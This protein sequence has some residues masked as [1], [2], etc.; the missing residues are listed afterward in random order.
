MWQRGGSAAAA[1]AAVA[2]TVHPAVFTRIQRCISSAPRHDRDAY[3][4]PATANPSLPPALPAA[5]AQIA[6]AAFVI[7][8]SVHLSRDSL[9]GDTCFCESLDSG[10][11]TYLMATARTAIAL[12]AVTVVLTVSAGGP[13]CDAAPLGLQ[14]MQCA[15]FGPCACGVGAWLLPAMLPALPLISL[16]LSA[17]PRAVLLLLHAPLRHA[18]EHRLLGVGAG[19]AVCHRTRHHVGRAVLAAQ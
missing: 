6:G 15:P 3:I 12:S 10:I 13:T 18:C 16:P 2:A 8:P 14:G 7:A 11:C 4:C 17:P 5:R 9:P 1:A 19:P